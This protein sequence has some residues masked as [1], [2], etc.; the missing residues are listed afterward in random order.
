MKSRTMIVALILII[1]VSLTAAF[2]YKDFLKNQPVREYHTTITLDDLYNADEEVAQALAQLQ[3]SQEKATIITGSQSSSRQIALT[4]DGLTDRATVQ[5]ILVLLKKYNSKATFFVDGLHTVE[6]PLTLTDIKDAGQKVENFTLLGMPKMENLPIERLAKDFCRAEK[7]VKENATQEPNLLKCNDTKYTDQVLQVA[8]ACGFKNVVQSDAFFNARKSNTSAIDAGAFVAA[9]R[10]G[11]IVSVKLLADMELITNEP[12]KTDLKPAIDKQPGLKEMP[13][14]GLG[15]PEIALA[16]EK[17]LI[18]LQ[19]AQYS[20][21]YV[22]DFAKNTSKTALQSDYGNK[23]AVLTKT[24]T[25]LQ[26]QIMALFSCR[27][28]YAAEGIGQPATEIKTIFT[29]EQALAYTFGGLTK[30]SVVND[31]LERLN[32]LGIKATFFVS[33]SELKKYPQIVRKIIAN[34]HEVGI[35]IRPKAGESLEETRKSIMSSSRLLKEQFGVSTNLVKQVSGAVSDT[36]KEAVGSLEYKLIG[37]SINIVQSKHKDYTSVDAIMSELFRKSM[38]SLSRGEILYFKMDFYTDDQIVGGLLESIKQ[39]KIDNIAY[40]T[41]YDNPGNNRANNSQYTIKPVGEIL[42]NTKN[43]YQ[44]PVDLQ[45][46]PPH[47]RRDGPEIAIDSH[48]FLATVSQH[49]IGK[50]TVNLED[51][52]VGFSKMDVRRLD[53]TG[54]VHTEDNV[55]FLTFDDWGS[56]AAINKL[57]YVLRKHNV[58][59]TFFIITNNVLY[60]PNLLRA[61]AVEGHEIGSHSDK[62]KP[63]AV[64]DPKTHK[65]VNTQEKEEYLKD[66]TTAYQKLRDVTGD[67]TSNGKPA[68]TRFFRS[69]TLAISKTGMEALLDAGYDYIISGSTSSDDYKAKDVTQLVETIKEGIFTQYGEVKKG[70]ILVMHMTDGAIYTPTALDIL[71]TANEAK[72]D[73]D[74]SKFKVGRLSDYLFDGYSQINP[75]KT[76]RLLHSVDNVHK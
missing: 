5:Q 20:T 66:L 65:Y 23:F 34:K 76:L 55:I 28:A 64:M 25:F 71:L 39:N 70:S 9:L 63:M 47:L 52:M 1:G 58:P 72:A 11:S 12:G 13:Q 7:I 53:K 42:N 30:E 74:P 16:V 54:F 62:H 29:T 43:I 73:S 61:I 22:E 24:V 17:L 60:N 38:F 4:F 27:V 67:V 56:D 51:R 33:E 75:K 32:K 10:S 45:K 49:Y 8:K 14:E 3:K 40:A 68:L 37:Q 57:L 41:F 2:F 69:P 36:T 44:Y 18:A 35:A 59:G 31:I 21:V 26:E 6:D 48:N 50:S 46:V 15:E 19:K